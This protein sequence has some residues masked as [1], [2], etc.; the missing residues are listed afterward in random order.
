MTPQ[1][2]ST[3]FSFSVITNTLL[4]AGIGMMMLAGSPSSVVTQMESN[5]ATSTADA[6]R[7][8]EEI[9]A[10]K[11]EIDARKPWGDHI[12]KL[13]SELAERPMLSLEKSEFETWRQKAVEL[14]PNLELPPLESLVVQ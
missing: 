5:A 6:F 11:A 12:E 3:L 13:D 14:N 1:H 4:C 7:L 2:V 10:V 8:S 9:A